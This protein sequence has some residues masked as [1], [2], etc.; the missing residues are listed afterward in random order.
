MCGVIKMWSVM[1]TVSIYASDMC[2]CL[3]AERP[4]LAAS[5]IVATVLVNVDGGVSVQVDYPELFAGRLDIYATTNILLNEWVLLG[6][7][8]STAGTNAIVWHDA[9]A[10]T[11]RTRFYRAGN[12]DLDADSDGLADARELL[13][14]LTNPLLSDSDLDDVPD[15]AEV[16][17]GTDPV[18]SGSSSIV[19]YIDSDAGSDGFDGFAPEAAD[20]HGPKRS[21]SAAVA[22][23]YTRDLIQLSGANVYREPDLWIGSTD[24]TLRPLGL[25]CV[26][27]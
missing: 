9:A 23:S 18:G 1:V 17:R 2:Y 11:N 25:V 27:P 20:G 15:G 26:Q 21:L 6:R 4:E 10:G 13:I 7:D 8:L 5:N 24:L 16:A 12:A 22:V 14:Y 19:L 3:A